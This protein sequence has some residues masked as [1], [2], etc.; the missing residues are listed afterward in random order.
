VEGPPIV[1]VLLLEKV[2][3]TDD[4]GGPY[5]STSTC[6]ISSRL[7]HLE[8]ICKNT[9]IMAI[10]FEQVHVEKLRPCILTNT[11]RHEQRLFILVFPSITR[12]GFAMDI[13]LAVGFLDGITQRSLH[14]AYIRTY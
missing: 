2:I 10:D 12:D 7:I 14:F 5:Y 11:L 1:S 3:E 4:I 8:R 9:Y 6:V 13:K